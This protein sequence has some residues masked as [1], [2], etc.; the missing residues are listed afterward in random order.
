[1]LKAFTIFCVVLK[2][3][4]SIVPVKDYQ[5]FTIDS[6][7][8]V[9][10]T[11]EIFDR[12]IAEQKHFLVVVE[13]KDNGNPQLNSKSFVD[14]EVVDDNDNGPSFEPTEYSL[15]VDEDVPLG[16]V[17][18]FFTVQDNDVGLNTRVNFFISEGNQGQAFD[19]I[20]KISPNGGELVV[21]D[22]LDY[23]TTKEYTLR[24][25]ATD[26][27]SSSQAATVSIKVRRFVC[28]LVKS[29]HFLP[30]KTFSIKLLLL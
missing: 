18:Y 13:A 20:T 2:V 16:E 29:L 11:A 15:T 17:I 21:E 3:T 27:R 5:Y 22:K 10:R 4:Y 12:E 7:T 1:M 6:K 8:G 14:I 9:I 28:I 23:E 19:V 25:I 24:I 26:G 30:L